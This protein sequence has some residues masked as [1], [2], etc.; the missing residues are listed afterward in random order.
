MVN[1]EHLPYPAPLGWL[2]EPADPAP[3][4][5]TLRELLARDDTDREVLETRAALLASPAVVAAFATQR[6][7]G[8]WGDLAGDDTTDG[9]AWT[10]A[11]LLHQG[12]PARDP[13]L[14]K[15]ARALLA[16]RHVAEID[17]RPQLPAGAWS[18]SEEP[19]DV[20]SCV[21]GDGLALA[22]TILG[23]IE[24][25]RRT[26]LWLLA[27]QRHDG[28]WLHCHRWSLKTRAL[29][30]LASRRLA[31]PEE[32]D[33]AVRSCRFGTFRAL[34]G[35]AALPYELRDD[36]VRKALLR[37]AEHFLSRHVTGRLDAPH[38]DAVPRIRSFSSGFHLTGTPLRQ[39]LDLL[40]VARLLVDLGHGADERLARTLG[41]LRALQRPD[42][43]WDCQAASPGMLAQPVGEPSKWVTLDALA[44]LQ[45]AA[46]TRGVEL[47]L[48]G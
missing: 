19:R 48:G 38:T 31:W 46:R 21:T 45:R 17:D 5:R 14:V 40:S 22:L 26:V 33:P 35:L 4:L 20:A 10:L 1:P 23:P 36:L 28:G 2:L 8:S 47:A 41:R 32:T 43:R 27:H 25:N 11:W 39:T 16:A 9:T 37:G 24:E 30:L 44:T 13:R 29:S 3:R 34:R 18:T 12:V 6:E 15:G 42:G 7:D